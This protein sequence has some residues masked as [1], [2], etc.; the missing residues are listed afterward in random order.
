MT[1][2]ATSGNL[3]ASFVSLEATSGR[4]STCIRALRSDVAAISP[5]VQEIH[6][7]LSTVG[8]RL[9]KCENLLEQL[10]Q[11][12]Q[13]QVINESPQE[14]RSI[15]SIPSSPGY[16]VS[17]RKLQITLER[18]TS[19]LLAK[20]GFLRDVCDA[21]DMVPRPRSRGMDVA[22]DRTATNPVGNTVSTYTGGRFS[23]LCRHRRRLRT[24]NATWGPLILSFD[25]ATEEHLPKC[26][27]TRMMIGTERSK[28]VS[29]TYTGLRRLLK[30]AVQISFTMSWGAGGAGSLSPNFTYYPSVD[31]ETAPAFRILTLLTEFLFAYGL[32]DVAI[33]GEL[34][35][36]AVSAIIRLF[37]VKKASPRA[38][39]AYNRSLVYYL[40]EY[41]SLRVVSD[42]APLGLTCRLRLL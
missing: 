20:P 33:Q 5:P 32:C 22:V 38:V 7:T 2:E 35:S 42:A 18:I 9:E 26:P 30:L 34:V 10:L 6:S 14:V 4:L 12:V 19:R 39:D 1:L 31:S 16:L 29:F 13:Q 21:S 3:S 25:L 17:S 23:C 40:A 15:A 27:A 37:Q 8:P 41:V 28:K 36:S 11:T 24:T